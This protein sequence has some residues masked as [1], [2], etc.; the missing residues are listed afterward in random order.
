MGA[1]GANAG[2][3]LSALNTVHK[4]VNLY[5]FL[6]WITSFASAGAAVAKGDYGKVLRR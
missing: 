6:S 2:A 1:R 3:A 4:A 5:A